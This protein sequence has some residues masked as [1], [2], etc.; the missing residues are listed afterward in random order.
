LLPA[1]RFNEESYDLEQLDTEN[2]P[3][4]STL[5]LF[6]VHILPFSVLCTECNHRCRKRCLGL[7]RITQLQNCC[8]LA[9]IR[10]KRSE[11]KKNRLNASWGQIEFCY[12]GDVLSTKARVERAVRAGVASSWKRWKDIGDLLRNKGIPLKTGG[13]ISENRGEM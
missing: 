6:I 12:L 8:C 1:Q 5:F 13:G 7:K 2:V 9:C 11:V 3:P 10:G 4:S